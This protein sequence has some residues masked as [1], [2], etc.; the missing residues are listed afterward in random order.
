[1]TA[2]RIRIGFL[3]ASSS[4]TAWA[5]TSHIPYLLS[6]AGQSKYEIVAL[7]NSSLASGRAAIAALGIPATTK[8]YDSASALAA[9]PSV[10]LVVC[11]V[12][13]AKH[14]ELIKP[15]LLAGK[16][17]YV[18]WPLGANISEAE[19]LAQIAEEKGVRTVV[20]LQGRMDH[21]ID[22]IKST[23]DSGKIGD[24]HS[25]SISSVIA[26]VQGAQTPEHLAYLLDAKSGGTMASIIFGHCE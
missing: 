13:V 6:E 22:I 3:G 18:E 20:G 24:V 5:N 17:A 12:N 4:R 25:S 10:D 16:M 9:D 23:V 2:P 1:M 19:E 7:C 15:A 21:L 14:Y 8:V 11:S 26:G